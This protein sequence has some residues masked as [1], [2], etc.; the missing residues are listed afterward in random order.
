MW[1]LFV[2][3]GVKIGNLGEKKKKSHLWK[4]KMQNCHLVM[5][6]YLLHLFLLENRASE[7]TV[8]HFHHTM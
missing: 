2:Q 6:L 7:G 3:W 5:A 8:L 4:N 1:L